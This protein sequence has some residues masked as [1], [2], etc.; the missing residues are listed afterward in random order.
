MKTA[1]AYSPSVRE[2][3]AEAFRLTVVTSDGNNSGQH[4][5]KNNQRLIQNWDQEYVE[6]SGFFGIHDPRIFAAALE[7]QAAL[8]AAQSALWQYVN[9]LHYPPTGDSIERRA[10]AAKDAS[11]K[12]D[13]A[14]ALT[15]T[16]DAPAGRGAE[17]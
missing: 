9:D 10:K 7:M 16:V 14:L 13:A 15:R 3:P 1:T 2:T 5:I 4:T 6:I 17:S 12:V 8:E 11:D